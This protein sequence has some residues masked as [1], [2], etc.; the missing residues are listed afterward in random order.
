MNCGKALVVCIGNELVADD[1]VGHELYRLLKAERLPAEVRIEFCGVGGIALL[2][3]LTGQEELLLVVDAVQF[4]S[5]PGSVHCLAWD[6]LPAM[7]GNAISA[8]GIGLKDTISIGQTLYPERMPRQ[9][10]LVGVEG[11]CF[12][13]LGGVMTTE[14]AAA[15]PRALATIHH[16]LNL[17]T[18]GGC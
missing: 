7:D 4:G 6:Q 3:L 12:D 16:A 13:Q 8:H 10:L 11:C 5:P 14:V 18:P 15:L 17:A 2:E 1:A 9:V